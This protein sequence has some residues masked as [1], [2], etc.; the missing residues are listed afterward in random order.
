MAAWRPGANRPS[1]SSPFAPGTAPSGWTTKRRTNC[2]YPSG[3]NP[4]NGLSVGMSSCRIT[5]ISSPH[6]AQTFPW[7]DGSSIGRR[8]S[9]RGTGTLSTDGR[10]IIG[11]GGCGQGRAIA[12]SGST[13]GRIRSGKGWW[14]TRTIGRTRARSTAFIGE[15][16]RAS[17]PT[18]R[19]WD[20]AGIRAAQQKLRPPAPLPYV[21]PPPRN[22]CA[23][24]QCLGSS[25]G[26]G[27]ARPFHYTTIAIS[28][29]SALIGG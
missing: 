16:G 13:F 27:N 14:M 8:R 5:S 6:E 21:H 12:R 24:S 3:R 26:R 2:S 9:P 7:R 29:P 11:I 28:V 15:I 23:D 18:S 1:S 19:V 25:Q 4:V 22:L 17:R 20:Q 10:R